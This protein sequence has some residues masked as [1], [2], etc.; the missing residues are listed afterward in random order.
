MYFASLVK[1]NVR[2]KYGEYTQRRAY[3]NASR[4]LLLLN[5]QYALGSLIERFDRLYAPTHPAQDLDV[6]GE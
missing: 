3:V 1:N 5:A 4:G 2:E 6:L